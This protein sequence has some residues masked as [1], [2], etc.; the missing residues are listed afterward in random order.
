MITAGKKQ[1]GS[2]QV[3]TRTRREGA[4]CTENRHAQ[5]TELQE[6]AAG[7][8]AGLGTDEKNVTAMGVAARKETKGLVGV[9]LM[10]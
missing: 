2:N 7:A 4:H 9:T 10:E 3:E 1:G 5:E 8:A 6:I